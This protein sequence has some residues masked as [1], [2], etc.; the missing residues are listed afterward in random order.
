MMKAIQIQIQIQTQWKR[1]RKRNRHRQS[2]WNT[3]HM[4]YFWNPDDSRIPNMM[5]DSSPSSSCSRWS[6]RSPCSGHRISSTGPSVSPFRDFYKLLE[7]YSKRNV[8]FIL[9]RPDLACRCRF[10]QDMYKA[11]ICH[12][13]KLNFHSSLLAHL[14]N[15]NLSPLA[16]STFPL[17]TSI[18]FRQNSTV[19]FAKIGWQIHICSTLVW[20]YVFRSLC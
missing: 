14:S 19:Q 18:G 11:G 13:K 17:C 9:F 15:L 20:S 7:I 6:P 2:A 1:Q 5:I 12:P 3:Q 10:C 4:L 16:R 8:E